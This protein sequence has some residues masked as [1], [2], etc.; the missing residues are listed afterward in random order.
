MG[1]KFSCN[2]DNK[3]LCVFQLTIELPKECR[4]SEELQQRNNKR[5]E[6]FSPD[7][8]WKDDKELDDKVDKCYKEGTKFQDEVSLYLDHNFSNYNGTT[9]STYVCLKCRNRIREN[10][11]NNKYCILENYN[12]EGYQSFK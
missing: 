6:K 12:S 9:I 3:S 1:N 10:N 5:F 7:K 2:C 11:R 4:L 8:I